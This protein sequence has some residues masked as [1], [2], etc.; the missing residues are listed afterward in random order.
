MHPS[1][2]LNILPF[3]VLV[4]AAPTKRNCPA[5]SADVDTESEIQIG[6][7]ALLAS[8]KDNPGSEPA[9]PYITGTAPLPSDSGVI[10]AWDR[11]G[12]GGWGHGYHTFQAAAPV[13]TDPVYT[14]PVDQT[15]V[16]PSYTDTPLPSTDSQDTNTVASPV[17]PTSADQ[18]EN[19][20][21]TSDVTAPLVTPAGTNV[22]P[23]EAASPSINSVGPAISSPGASGL[24]GNPT[25]SAVQPISSTPTNGGAANGIGSGGKAGLGL[26]DTAWQNLGNPQGLGWYWN[27]GYKPF[28]LQAEFV[29]CIWGKVMANEFNGEL[30]AG[31]DYIMSFNEPDQGADVGGSIKIGSPAVARGGEIWFNSWVTAC[32]GDCKYDFVPIHFYGT[33]VEDMITYI[34]S[35]PSGGKPIWV[36][37]FDCQDFG[38]GE[39]CDA[40]TQKEFMNKAIE[41]FKG[42][43][44]SIVERWSWFG[45]IPRFSG[46]TYGLEN[47]DGTLNELGQ[48]Y[49]S[50]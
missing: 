15:P 10:A 9:I 5:D 38:T 39:V 2:L 43:G 6:A 27:W 20:V 46:T 31:V 18:P 14:Q 8:G 36:A 45:A 21:T 30:L 17:V 11:G 33:I 3:L 35:F 34:K 28:D 49:L 24:P 47:A 12:R 22:P 16:N 13:Y 32:G 41:W 40:T 4:T 50:L 1:T 29:A 26:D 44:S 23:T 19:A 7:D 48:Y 42:E 37:E 25:S